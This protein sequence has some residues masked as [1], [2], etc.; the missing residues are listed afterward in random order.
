MIGEV[1]E[2]KR[3]VR[4]VGGKG[5][6]KKKFGEWR[7]FDLTQNRGKNFDSQVKRLLYI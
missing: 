2:V 3:E 6:F 4:E 5:D 1:S 7:A